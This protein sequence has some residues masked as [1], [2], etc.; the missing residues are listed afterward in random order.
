M[1]PVLEKQ[2]PGAAGPGD[3]NNEEEEGQNLWQVLLLSQ[4][5]VATEPLCGRAQ[6]VW[7]FC[8]VTAG[9]SQSNTGPARGNVSAD[10]S[11]PANGST[12]AS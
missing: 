6:P 2:L 3:N 9:C 7:F 5:F 1:A 10:V 11:L 8:F 12:A 4:D